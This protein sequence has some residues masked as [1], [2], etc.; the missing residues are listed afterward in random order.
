MRAGRWGLDL[1]AGRLEA[2]RPRLRDALVSFEGLEMRGP[3]VDC[4]EDHAAPALAL[5]EM[6]LGCGLYAAAQ[7]LRAS[8]HRTRSPQRRA[9]WEQMV[10]RLRSSLD[11]GAFHATCAA[12]CEWDAG[13]V[14]RRV[15]GLDATAAQRLA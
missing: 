9:R 5:G 13:E 1:R 7:R 10:E 8:T 3:W 11:A 2:A 15:L 12:A 4:V 14:K 6:P